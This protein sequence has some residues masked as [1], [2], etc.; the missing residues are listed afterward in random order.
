M[1]KKINK[2]N[3]NYV[4]GFIAVPLG[5]RN[6]STPTENNNIKP[7]AVYTNT[8]AQKL[9]ILKENKNKSGIYR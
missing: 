9:Q 5:T 8:G 1:I 7:A 6:F 2:L 3:Q 4:T